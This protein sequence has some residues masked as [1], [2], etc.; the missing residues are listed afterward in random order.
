MTGRPQYIHQRDSRLGMQLALACLAATTAAVVYVK[1]S[2]EYVLSGMYLIWS[3]NAVMYFFFLKGFANRY[4]SKLYVTNALHAL[5]GW[6]LIDLLLVGL[7][8]MFF[9]SS[10]QHSRAALEFVLN[11]GTFFL[12]TQVLQKNLRLFKNL[13]PYALKSGYNPSD[14]T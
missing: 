14:R 6:N 4:P 9:S 2:G 8:A 1:F 11:L 3:L 12:R 7:L 10:E 5:S 13:P